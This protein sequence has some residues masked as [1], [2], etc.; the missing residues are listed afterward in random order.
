MTPTPTRR[1]PETPAGRRPHAI[2]WI[3]LAGCVCIIV[4]G[5]LAF[6]AVYPWAYTPL[7]I[8][9]A[10]IGALSLL[11]ERHGRPPLA[12]LALGLVAIGLAIALQLAPMPLVAL[13][14]L[15]PGTDTFLRQY[16]LAYRLF[17]SDHAI[18][19]VPAKTI[20][21]G[22][23]FAS[24]A[25][26]LL[27]VSR[28]ISVVGA[29]AI[30]RPVAVFGTVLALVGI[31]QYALTRD[32]V[33]PL[34][35][36]FWKPVYESHPFG[37]F[38]NPNHFGGW[39]VMALPLTLAMFFETLLDTIRSAPAGRSGRIEL[40]SSRR[41]GALLGLALACSV[42]GLSLAM[43]R[44]RSALASFAVGAILVGWLA[45][46][47]Q[48]SRTARAG[49][50]ALVA[51]LVI[52]AVSWAGVNMVVSKFTESQGEKSLISRVSAWK[53]TIRIVGDFPLAGTGFDTYGTA[54]DSVP[55][56]PGDAA[57]RRGPQRLPAD[58]RRGRPPG[59]HSGG[60]H[61]PRLRGRRAAAIP[62]GPEGRLD[63]LA[64]RR[65][66]HRPAVDRRPV[67]RR[68]Q[69]PDARQRGPLRRSRG[70]RPPPVPQPA[71][72]QSRVFSIVVT[73]SARLAP[74]FRRLVRTI[75]TIAPRRATECVVIALAASATEG[76]GL[77]LL[78]PLLQ[79]VGVQSQSGPL[80][81]IVAACASAFRWVG[82]RPT[83]GVVLL[84][85]VAIVAVQTALQQ[86]QTIANTHLEQSLVRALRARVYRAISETTWTYFARTRASNYVRVLT[87]DVERTGTAAHYVLDLFVSGLASLV[88][89]ALAFRV[90]PSMTVLVMLCGATLGVTARRRLSAAHAVGERQVQ[91]STR[92]YGA[93]TEQL[94][95]VKMAKSYGAKARH[96]QLFDELSDDV[97]DSSLAVVRTYLRLRWQ[98]AIGSAAL[99]AAVV[100][101][102]YSILAVPTASLLLLLFLFARLVPRL[103]GTYERA[104]SL[105]TVLPA[106]SSLRAVEE[107]CAAEAEPVAASHESI[108]LT[109]P[110]AF[111]HVTFSYDPGSLPPALHDVSLTCPLGATT[112]IVGVSGAGKSTLADLLLGLATPTAGR[113]LVGSQ[114]LTST[115]LESWRAQIGYV[116]QDPF[117]FHDTVRANLIWAK[118]DATETDVWTALRLAS[119]DGFVAALPHG[120]DTI[121]G[122]RGVLLSGGERQRLSLARALVRQPKLLVLDEAT[123]SLDSE[124]ERRIQDAVDSLRQQVTIVVI[125]HRLSTIRGADVIHV[126]DGGELIESG[127]WDTLIARPGG[128]FVELCRAQGIGAGA[129]SR[130][131]APVAPGMA[132]SR[133]E[134]AI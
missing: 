53:D 28:L 46:K 77:L 5:A 11:V 85:Y 133:V 84:A 81:A 16:Q 71:F 118:P 130:A 15:S 94:A 109:G 107:R 50:A 73:V 55:E 59:G 8:A 83:L 49:I 29:R 67:V 9:A 75:A 69:P 7:A 22:L 1:S 91:A 21:G 39:M 122:D 110:V 119:A 41:F 34:I 42:M 56:Q 132:N 63:I 127:T 44:S 23:L 65:G 38:V 113:I 86:R 51:A 13:R 102:S 128:R 108:A 82:L 19:I 105:A 131:G 32:D 120:L 68:V 60:L 12:P 112:A 90:S 97:S 25:L 98:L 106:F 89:V 114:E 31:V 101:V 30:S 57:L 54:M 3:L 88:Y 18:S 79:L 134:A 17:P 35:Y 58:R 80:S 74:D 121:V 96:T 123:S 111:E 14:H 126:V 124:N 116:A 87:E 129:P 100:Y 2:H 40:L 125:T 27:G 6:G 10:T 93:I 45:A 104:Q 24:L 33:Q 52:G 115:R 36:G 26:F 64:A 66:R 48:R 117:L 43:T 62:R 103:T 20:L 70:N 4:W 76:V 95:S 78:V 92:L 99:L 61:D 47:R 37:P 72:C